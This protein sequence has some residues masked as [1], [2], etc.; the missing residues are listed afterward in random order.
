[1]DIRIESITPAKAT[2]YLNDNKANR[3]LRDGVVERYADDMAKGRWTNCPEP[4]SFYE[5]GDLAD[6]QHRLW[7]IVESNT[8]QTFPVAR[9][10]KRADGLNINTG[11]GRSLV[12]N[13]RI[14]GADQNLTPSI[15][16]AARAIAF[17]ATT[18]SKDNPIPRSNAATV[19]VVQKYREAAE[20][21]TQRV[22]RVNGLCGAVVLGAVGRAYLCGVDRNKL[23]RYCDVLGN[24]F[25]D[26]EHE[27]AAVAMRN[28]LIAKKGVA[29]S[30]AL[31]RD[32]FMKVQNSITYFA[33]GKKLTVIK[34]VSEEAYPLPT[35]RA[36]SKK[37]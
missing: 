33:A 7:A 36:S 12:D 10:L 4:I 29:S 16:S 17:G 22:K 24:G 8:T 9:G 28:Y 21:A 1:M 11:L 25:A 19:E 15:I 26:G 32:T 18:S 30:T 34:G 3:K 14:S 5:D 2:A 13:A 35:K 23:H 6:G 37:A 27:S 20:W 31:W